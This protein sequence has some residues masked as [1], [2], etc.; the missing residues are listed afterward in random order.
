MKLLLSRLLAIT[1]SACFSLSILG[2]AGP[3]HPLE[4]LDSTK[5]SVVIREIGSPMPRVDYNASCLLIPASITKA[6]TS[7]CVIDLLGADGS[8]A[9]TVKT[10]GNII[11]G[12]LHGRLVIST[13]GDP[14][15][16]SSRM[17]GSPFVEEVVKAVKSAGIKNI[18]G[19]IVINSPNRMI[20][21]VPGGW[22]KEDLGFPYGAAFHPS[23]YADNCF[24]LTM[25]SAKCN[26]PVPDL[27][28]TRH[29]SRGK[30]RLDKRPASNH[31]DL[32]G[33]NLNRK[34]VSTFPNSSPDLSLRAAV[35]TAL[36]DNGIATTLSDKE[37]DSPTALLAIHHSAKYVDILRDLMH[38]SDNLF[39]EGMLMSLSP[40]GS[41][42]DAIEAERL[43][44]KRIIR[45]DILDGVS[46]ED[47]S[48]LSRNNR[49]SA[50]F[51][52]EMLNA[53]AMGENCELYTSLFPR[54][55]I[56]GT[57][58]RLLSLSPLAGQLVLKSGSMRGV[59]CYAGYKLDK[60]NLPTHSVVVMVNGFK[61]NSSRLRQQIEKMLLDSFESSGESQTGF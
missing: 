60:D 51:M 32:Y 27:K 35:I 9:T 1:I 34:S 26:P 31:I 45:P 16:E 41:R 40:W 47:G 7:A 17:E 43:L 30:Y 49:V 48:G 58:K 15:L 11:D 18:D 2:S 55:G 36:K 52:S 37:P 33:K 23:T 61:G 56:E 13:S 5:Y 21:S 57:V 24:E 38:R 53:M 12:T 28:I 19:D 10:V 59:R 8:F 42:N 3:L 25:P 20:Q 44:L 50:Q 39:A 29:K 14:T 54:A 46:I 4:G 22:E 6:I